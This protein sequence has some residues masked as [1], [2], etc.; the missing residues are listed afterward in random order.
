MEIP[1]DGGFGQAGL[2]IIRMMQRT[3]AALFLS[4]AVLLASCVQ[5]RIRSVSI[6]HRIESSA[7]RPTRT[8]E[9]IKFTLPRDLHVDAK[10]GMPT[11]IDSD[12]RAFRAEKLH[13]SSFND[14]ET[15]TA[16]FEIV[17]NSHAAIVRFGAFDV[18]I[19]KRRVVRRDDR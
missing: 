6:S 15:V 14:V 13:V 7:D 2:R 16:E 12:G 8:F 4:V 18:D 17:H 5:D 19:E 10:A 9:E 3:I 1:R 11:M